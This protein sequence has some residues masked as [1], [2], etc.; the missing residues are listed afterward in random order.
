M[1]DDQKE[2]RLDLTQWIDV[3]RVPDGGIVAGDVGNKRV[4]VWR[5]GSRLKAYGADCPHLGGPLNKGIVVGDIRSMPLAPC[6]LQ[7]CDRRSNFCSCF[8]RVARVSGRTPG[9]PLL[10]KARSWGKRLYV[11]QI[12]EHRLIRW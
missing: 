3:E 6:M 9:Y 7:P 12:A 4:F 10:R 5:T 2:N 8:R 1:S 11:S